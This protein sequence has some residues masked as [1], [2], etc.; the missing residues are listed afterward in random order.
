[1]TL[2]INPA[3]V[4]DWNHR[5]GPWGWAVPNSQKATSTAGSAPLKTALKRARYAG[6][7]APTEPGMGSLIWDE[8][9]KG[10][11]DVVVCSSDFTRATGDA[12]SHVDAWM[13]RP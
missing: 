6:Q 13:K 9:R 4:S 11:I 8:D 5:P 1:M 3:A 2:L 12:T 7:D 10:V